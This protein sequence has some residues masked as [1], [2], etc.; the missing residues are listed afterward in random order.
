[1]NVLLFHTP[2]IDYRPNTSFFDSGAI[3]AESSSCLSSKFTCSI[4]QNNDICKP[5]ENLINRVIGSWSFGGWVVMAISLKLLK[6]Q[7]RSG[8]IKH[9]PSHID[10]ITMVKKIK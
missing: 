3:S 4:V 1:M 10:E 5:T 6:C 9:Y 7:T 2:R 8:T